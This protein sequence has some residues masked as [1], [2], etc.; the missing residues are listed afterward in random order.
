[1]QNLDVHEGQPVRGVSFGNEQNYLVTVSEDCSV[2]LF[3]ASTLKR[4]AM[5]QDAHPNHIYC[6]AM[7][8]SGNNFASGGRD[9]LVCVWDIKYEGKHVA[10]WDPS[11]TNAMG[12]G[13][14]SYPHAR[15]SVAAGLL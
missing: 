6:V 13:G 8:P 5:V 7:G 2:R 1:M 4:L 3:N 11:T 15:C 9:K 14:G 12:T 10:G